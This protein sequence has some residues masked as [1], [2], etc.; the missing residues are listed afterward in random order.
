M[1]DYAI[2]SHACVTGTIVF[3]V[4]F[5]DAKIFVVLDDNL[6]KPCNV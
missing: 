5:S 1:T 4:E 6:D 3:I 2:T